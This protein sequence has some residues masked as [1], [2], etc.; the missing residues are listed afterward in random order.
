VVA[1]LKPPHTPQLGSARWRFPNHILGIAECKQRLADSISSFI[2][3]QQEQQPQ[4]TPVQQWEAIKQ[5]AAAATQSIVF[6]RQEQQRQQRRTLLAA[7]RTAAGLNDRHPN[8]TAVANLLAAEQALT[9]HEE[10]SLAAQTAATEPLWELYGESSTFWFHRLGKQQPEQQ[11]ILEVDKPG[12]GKVSLDTPQ[13]VAAA[14]DLLADFYDPRASGL[15]SCHPT[16]P[17]QQQAMLGAVDKQLSEQA[18]K[19][20]CGTEADGLLTEAEAQAALASLPRG[21]SPGSDG[22]T[23]EFYNAMWDLVVKPMVAAFNHSYSQQQPQLSAQQRLGLILLIYKGGDKSRSDPASYRPIT[24]LNC[25]LKIVAKLLV[26][27][28]GPALHE[29]IDQTQTAFVPGR[30]IADN[31]LLHLEEVDYLQESFML[32]QQATSSSHQ[33][34]QQHS[35]CIVFLDFEKAYDRLDRGWLFQCMAAMAFPAQAI[36]WVE[37]LLRG[38]QGMVLFNGGHRSRVF[39][40]PSGCAQGSPLSPLLYVIAAQPLAARCRQLQAAGSFRGISMPDGAPAPCCHQHAD[41]TTLHAATVQDVSVLL[42]QA[43]DP[44]CAASAAKLNVSKSQGM[45]LGSHPVLQGVDP[46]TGVLFPDTLQHPIRHL[47]VLLSVQGAVLHA[48]RLFRQRLQT[49]TWRV[50][51]WA[52]YDLTLLGRCEVAKQVLASCLAYHA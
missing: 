5:H 47:G 48:P 26:L 16:D 40:I 17:Q 37:L 13:G 43:V 42:Q 41:D 38:T 12:G 9:A 8:A 45:V 29:V 35:G 44:F 3:E 31:V 46:V 27:R 4:L 15:F 23:Y 32:Q 52:Q 50:R 1:K 34:L 33:P 6:R 14:A 30:D 36:K 19:Q 18:Q 10:A 25:D 39:D 20:C 28:F 49:I 7:I 21:K 22:L 2:G 51:Q 24:L 11:H